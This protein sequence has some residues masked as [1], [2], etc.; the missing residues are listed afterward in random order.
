MLSDRGDEC[1]AGEDSLKRVMCT[2]LSLVSKDSCSGAKYEK[3]DALEGI[4]LK[5]SKVSLF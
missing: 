5:F 2:W 3:L 4:N 1:K